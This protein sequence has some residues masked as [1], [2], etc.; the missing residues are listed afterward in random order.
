M[1][2]HF[3]FIL[4][5]SATSLGQA[6]VV[7]EIPPGDYFEQIYLED[8]SEGTHVVATGVRIY[9][10]KT[11][12]FTTLPKFSLHSA[13]ER[14][15][16]NGIGY[17]DTSVLVTRELPNEQIYPLQ[18]RDSKN[19]SLSGVSVI[20]L[21]SRELP[22]RVMKE[23]WDGDALLVKHCEG[24]VTVKDVYFSNTEDGFGPGRGLKHWTLERAWMENIRDDAIEND[25]LIPGEVV[26]CLIEGCFVFLSQR[27]PEG[28]T[29]ELTTV[30]RDSLI[31]ITAQPHDG[32]EGKPWRDRFIV[33]DA[34]GIGRAPGMFFK[35]ANSAG[36][37]EVKNCILRMDA[38]S[39]NGPDDM[40]FP[41]G[42]YE[43]VTL[44]WTGREP[45][46]VPLPSG[47]EVI[48]DTS[49]WEEAKAA[50][51]ANLPETH[52]GRKQE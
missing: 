30:V 29:A 38:V 41:P 40:R 44:V 16:E 24:T 3:L 20:G 26:N 36:R 15:P 25:D 13:R 50:W 5:L 48:S 34:D 39:I 51:I 31:H 18:L 27:C 23:M 11:D 47:V 33:M 49:V 52:P 43:N 42:K 28:R 32:A 35:W 17:P 9:G 22:W 46:P 19:L 4:A 6:Q 37:V 21:Q 2:Q 14:D 45:Y 7:K 8:L 1:V 12:Q 10:G